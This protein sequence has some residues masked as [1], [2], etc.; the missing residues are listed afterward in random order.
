VG[1]AAKV[2]VAAAARV[3]ALAKAGAQLDALAKAG[4]QLGRVA[5]PLQPT[6]AQVRVAEQA[7]VRRARRA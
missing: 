3:D 5:K 7:R 2:D 6:A 4:A 1:V